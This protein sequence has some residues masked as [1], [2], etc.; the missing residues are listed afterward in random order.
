MIYL[1]QHHLRQTNPLNPLPS[2]VVLTAGAINVNANCYSEITLLVQYFIITT[3]YCYCARYARTA[4]VNNCYLLHRLA[5][6]TSLTYEWILGPQVLNRSL[7]ST[8]DTKRHKRALATTPMRFKCGEE[9]NR[10]YGNVVLRS[11]T[12]SMHSLLWS[13]IIREFDT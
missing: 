10:G 6:N 12:G 7:I 11:T 4:L 13:F 1:Q 9:Y 5:R 2:Y 8:G 3:Q